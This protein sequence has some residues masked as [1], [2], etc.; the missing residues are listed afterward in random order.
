MEIVLIRHGQPEWVKDGLNVVDPPLTDLGHEQAARMAELLADEEFDEVLVSPLQR[1]RQTAAPLYERLGRPEQI[2][3]W[4]E[5]I[6]D[7]GWHGTPAEKAQ[8]AYAELKGRAADQRWDGL[9]GGES[10]REFTDRIHIGATEFL[11][12]RSIVR[13]EHELPIW[14]PG[15]YGKRIA[16]VAH[17][18][19]N[20][21]TIGHLLG[22]D[23]TPWEWDRFV[24]GHASISRVEALPVKDGW[25]FSL[26]ALSNAE[27]IPAE[28]RSR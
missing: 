12:S 27:H 20:S 14:S 13:V 10:I 26:T 7:P 18:G 16:L 5:E 19:T 15:E 8:Q 22:L 4:L 2:E 3:P 6:R 25:T 21:I 1:A 23:A 28:R 9:D 11:R 17:A 24:L